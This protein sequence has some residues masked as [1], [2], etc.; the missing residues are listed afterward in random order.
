MTVLLS[1][2][3]TDAAGLCAQVRVHG[4]A[5]LPAQALAQ[6]AQV[7][8][9]ELAALEAG[10]DHRPPDGYLRDGGRYRRRRRSCSVV[11]AGHVRQAPHRA[12][13]QPVEYTPLHWRIRAMV[14]PV[15]PAPVAPPAGPALLR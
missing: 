3:L 14:Q 15:A 13:R 1:P 11:A 12:H 10:G 9:H 7:P 8:L 2:P 4:F 5:V 6:A